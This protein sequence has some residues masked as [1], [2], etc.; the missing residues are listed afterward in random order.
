MGEPSANFNLPPSTSLPP[1]IDFT[2]PPFT[3]HLLAL[4]ISIFFFYNYFSGV[5]LL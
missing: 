4:F 2:L 5:T 1:S 3:Q